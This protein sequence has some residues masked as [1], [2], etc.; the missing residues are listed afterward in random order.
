MSGPKVVNLEAIRR[1][2]QRDSIARLRELQDLVGEWRSA[3]ERAGLFTNE[4]AAGTAAMFGQLESLRQSEQ[5]A[6]LL[7][8]LSARREFF[9]SGIANARQAGIQRVSAL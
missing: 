3:M 2:Q 1:R 7:G 9:R 6:A 5:W 8:E 4:L